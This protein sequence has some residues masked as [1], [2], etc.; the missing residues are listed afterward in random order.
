M[1]MSE[2][3]RIRR[4]LLVGTT[5][6]VTAAFALSGCRAGT[7][8]SSAD[9]ATGQGL[10]I[11][12]SQRGISGSDW[13]KTLVEGGQAEAEKLGATIQLLDA[14]GDTVRQNS[15]VQ[16]LETKNVDVVVMNP[17][18][19]IGVGPSVASLAD[20][21]IP[22]VTV[23]SSLDASLVPDM[24]CYVAEDQEYT[25]SLAGTE[26]ANQALAR[27]D[28]G[29]VKI[30]GIGGFPGDVL[31]DLRFNGFK[32][33]FDAVMA[34]HPD[35]EVT[36]LDTKYGEWKPDK[37]LDPIRDAA[38]ANP[39]L[40]VVYSMSDV[41]NGG[42]VQGLQQAGLW[43][44]DVLLASYD[45]GMVS[46]Q[47]MVDDPTGPLIATASNQPWDQG[48]EAVRMAVAAYNGD[49]EACPDKTLYI[50]TTVVTPENA[51]DYLIPEDTY[52]RAKDDE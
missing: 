33:G 34:E 51:A 38:T 50:D 3:T 26:A 48:A 10:V 23:N 13:W 40:N 5:L 2:N 47:Q 14:N 21:G 11:G 24:F 18:D 6:L 1:I 49:T 19:P 9:K 28:G 30:L 16:T 4:R 20:A 7:D 35:T 8:E 43:G 36:Y 52:V 31:S 17:N 41:M 22:L 25:G 42:V 44:P 27:F 37:A 39:D 32:E 29:A 45:G 15:D 12:W 46:V